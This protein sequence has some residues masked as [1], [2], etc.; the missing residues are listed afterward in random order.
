MHICIYVVHVLYTYSNVCVLSIYILYIHI[1]VHVCVCARVCIVCIGVHTYAHAKARGGYCVFFLLLSS[2]PHSLR[3]GSFSVLWLYPDPAV[4][5][6]ANLAATKACRFPSLSLPDWHY[7]C[8]GH[9]QLFY[10]WDYNYISPLLP[11]SKPS[12]KLFP[13]L[14]QIH[15]F[16]SH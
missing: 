10:S 5:L 4:F 12:Q 3:L 14:L 9:T 16:F 7:R 2:P 6:S 1:C 8:C 15:G 13:A 11:P